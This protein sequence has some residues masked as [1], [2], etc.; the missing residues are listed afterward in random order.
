MSPV[1]ATGDIGSALTRMCMRHRSIE[2]K[3]RH[4]TKYE[5]AFPV[6]CL[7]CHS[8]EVYMQDKYMYA[9][10]FMHH[11][12]ILEHKKRGR[13]YSY[14]FH[15]EIIYETTTVVCLLCRIASLSLMVVFGVLWSKVFLFFCFYNNNQLSI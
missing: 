13:Q 6:I 11:K 8:L 5:K 10:D 7:L 15:A 9:Y 2:S 14:E 4:F 12:N 1:G 3:L